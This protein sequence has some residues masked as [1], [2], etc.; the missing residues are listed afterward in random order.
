MTHAFHLQVQGSWWWS[1]LR[2]GSELAPEEFSAPE[3]L[4]DSLEED[5]IAREMDEP[6]GRE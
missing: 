4:P 1:R 2:V 5:P 6:G 3:G